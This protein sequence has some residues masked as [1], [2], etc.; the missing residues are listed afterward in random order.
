MTGVVKRLSIF[1]FA[2]P[3]PQKKLEE[4]KQNT[5]PESNVLKLKDLCRTRWI[6]QIGTLDLIKKLYSSIVACFEN[7]SAEGSR[8]WSPDSVIDAS[9]LLL[10]IT[11]TEFVSA[12][13]IINECLQY[14]RGLTTSLQEEAK[15][16]VQ[17]VS[18]I[19]TLTSSLQQVRENVDSYHSKWFETVS[20]VC[21]EVGTTPSMLRICGCQR[22]RA[23][24]PASNPSEY[25]RRTIT[26]PILDHLLSELD[27]RF[28]S[29]QKTAFQG[30][31]L[32][33]SVLVTEDLA[34]VSSV[35]MKVGELYT[36]VDLPN[37]SSLS[38]EIHNWYPKRKSEEK[39][40]GLNS[41]PSTLSS[42]LTRISSFYPNIKALITTLHSAE[43]FFSSLKRIKTVLRSSMSNERLSSLTLLHMHQDI[44][45]I[46]KNSLMSSPDVIL[47]EFNFLTPLD[48]SLC[49]FIFSY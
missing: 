20:K 21:N 25:F 8:M 49:C 9:T 43:R 32:V 38:D 27:K 7:I 47:G 42:T 5:Q 17:A 37:V 22:H 33:P 28:S 29:H 19:K 13:V 48:S 35:V 36:V 24:I 26:V 16:I 30:P 1:F 39:D 15:D 12:L 44:P 3:K 4:A 14:L 40:H 10:V 45:L 11:R 6:E 34:T 2:H 18:E 46:S 31:Y 41:L 23:S